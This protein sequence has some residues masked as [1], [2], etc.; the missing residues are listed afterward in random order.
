MSSPTNKSSVTVMR[1]ESGSDLSL[2]KPHPTKLSQSTPTDVQLTQF[3]CLFFPKGNFTQFYWTWADCLAEQIG[4]PEGP[5]GGNCYGQR[6]S[7]ATLSIE[8]DIPGGNL[9]PTIIT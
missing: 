2:P 5:L 7:G 1:P 4:L 9:F 8:Q 3:S 6:R